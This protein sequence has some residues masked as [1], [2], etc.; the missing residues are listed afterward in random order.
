[1]KKEFGAVFLAC[2]LAA[3]AQPPATQQAA[4]PP[5]PAA[6]PPETAPG[7]QPATSEAQVSPGRW[8]V[9]RVRCSDLL[10]AAD[11]DRAAAAMFY[12]GYLAAKAGIRVIDVSQIDG[13]I[14]KVMDRCAAAPNITVP[15][16][17]R[18]AL[19]RRG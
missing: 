12:Y 7:Q 13:N 4:A 8:D 3:C 14:K 17:F 16:A 11:D 18:Q 15:L 5:A 9:E 10:G 2:C 19:G 1:M 6:P